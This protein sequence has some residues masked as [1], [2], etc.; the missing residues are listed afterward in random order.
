MCIV[1]G[2]KEAY[3]SINI[4]TQKISLYQWFVIMSQPFYTDG[5]KILFPGV[6]CQL[7]PL[8]SIAGTTGGWVQS[9]GE[10]Q[11][12]NFLSQS[13]SHSTL[14]FSRCF[15]S[16]GAFP[17]CSKVLVLTHLLLCSPSLPGSSCLSQFL[18]SEL[19]WIPIFFSFSFFHFQKLA[20]SFSLLNLFYLKYLIWVLFSWLKVT[21][22]K[23][24]FVFSHE[25]DK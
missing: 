22:N 25:L 19:I 6:L 13:H 12:V 9:G 5:L 21:Q 3:S 15:W 17:L 18:I 16:T 20:N 4:M 23:L 11:T 1:L 24:G 7:A 14:L 2:S 10:G 8:W